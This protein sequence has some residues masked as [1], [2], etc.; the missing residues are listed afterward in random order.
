MS[1]RTSKFIDTYIEPLKKFLK[2]IYIVFLEEL[3]KLII[4]SI[5]K[6]II[7]VVRS[8]V[9]TVSPIFQRILRYIAFF[10]L[11]SFNFNSDTVMLSE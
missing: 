11:S 6:N 2:N 7:S 5:R 10:F 9:E 8:V 3:E 4:E 1:C